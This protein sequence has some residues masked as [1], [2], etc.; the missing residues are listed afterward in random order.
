MRIAVFSTNQ[1]WHRF[2]RTGFTLSQ[3]KIAPIEADYL[4]SESQLWRAVQTK[5]YEIIIL[6]SPLRN[7]ISWGHF[8]ASLDRL[9]RGM[10]KNSSRQVWYFGGKMIA[11]YEEEIY[12]LQ[13][14]QKEV[15]VYDYHQS[16]RIGT[17]MKQEEERLSSA[18]FFRIH[19]NCL[20]N[21]I[22]VRHMEGS[23]LILRNGV[24]LSISSRRKKQVRERLLLFWDERGGSRINLRAVIGEK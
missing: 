9:W 24:S 10:V 15:S 3:D 2:F 11:M 23:N 17:N 5:R 8:L 22:H 20:V 13:S 7:R 18:Y 12:Y 21:L 16:Y 19:R 1:E 14:V 4:D 6:C